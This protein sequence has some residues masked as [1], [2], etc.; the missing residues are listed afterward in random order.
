MS[1]VPVAAVRPLRTLLV[2]RKYERPEKITSLLWT[3][4]A[5]REDNS[6]AL[7]EIVKTTPAANRALGA[8]AQPNWIVVTPPNRGIFR[9]DIAL[10]PRR[11][12]EEPPGAWMIDAKDVVQIYPWDGEEE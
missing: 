3:A 5:W 9:S 12:G 4:P 10:E 1:K 7:W 11:A 6:R 2:V 8:D